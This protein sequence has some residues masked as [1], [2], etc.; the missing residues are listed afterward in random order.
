LKKKLKLT[1]KTPKKY[2]LVKLGHRLSKCRK[3]KIHFGRNSLVEKHD[4]KASYPTYNDS[5]GNEEILMLPYLS[6]KACLLLK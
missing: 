1:K 6:K 3:L 5:N 4:L 2:I